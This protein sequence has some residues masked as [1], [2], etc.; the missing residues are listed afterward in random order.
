MAIVLAKE[1]ALVLGAPVR[2]IPGEMNP[3]DA[4]GHRLL[5]RRDL[6]VFMVAKMSARA[7]I[8]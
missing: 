2:L 4:P 5:S 8:S 7:T 1:F 3:R 6:D